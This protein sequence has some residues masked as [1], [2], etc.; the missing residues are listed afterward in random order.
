MATTVGAIGRDYKSGG[1]DDNDDDNDDN[2]DDDEGDD[3][4]VGGNEKK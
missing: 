1:Y 4:G 3:D 2:E